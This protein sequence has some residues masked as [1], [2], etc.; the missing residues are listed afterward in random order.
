VGGSVR[1]PQPVGLVAARTG[2][3][4]ALTVLVTTLLLL[5]VRP[6]TAVAAGGSSLTDWDGT[7]AVSQITATCPAP[8]TASTPAVEGAVPPSI[9]VAHNAINGQ[10]IS[11]SGQAQYSSSTEQIGDGFMATVKSDGTYSFSATPGGG[12]RFRAHG[13]V[14]AASLVQSAYPPSGGDRWS[15]VTCTVTFSGSRGGSVARPTGQPTASPSPGAV[16]TATARSS[17]RSSSF[18]YAMIG[19]GAGL[20]LVLLVLAL[21]V[22]R[23]R[24]HRPVSNHGR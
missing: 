19:G 9:T 7:Y 14:T 10:P 24:A 4:T 6:G 5:A 22:L 21:V 12:A 17:S 18:T 2:W 3:G 15:S 16:P 8:D 23:R 13:T 1:T 20:L 11:A